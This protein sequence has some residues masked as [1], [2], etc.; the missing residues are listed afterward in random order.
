MQIL[1]SLLIPLLS[2]PA[3]ANPPPPM[4]HYGDLTELFLAND[5]PGTC[6]KENFGHEE[7]PIEPC[8][9]ISYTV[10]T[11]EVPDT[12]WRIQKIALQAYVLPQDCFDSFH[13]EENVF[14]L[15]EGDTVR[16]F[17]AQRPQDLENCMGSFGRPLELILPPEWM[18]V[19]GKSFHTHREVRELGGTTLSVD[20]DA[21]YRCGPSDECTVV[22][23]RVALIPHQK[24][25]AKLRSTRGSWPYIVP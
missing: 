11:A 6:I 4:E 5:L 2:L 25:R 15:R 19:E 16:I 9:K 1:A 13:A 10:K 21:E 24:A 8:P 20:F 14:T 3:L 12:R 18:P 7:N 23:S 22:V 17:A